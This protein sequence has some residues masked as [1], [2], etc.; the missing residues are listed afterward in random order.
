MK[1]HGLP[2][3]R[4]SNHSPIRRPNC[5]NFLPFH[6]TSLSRGII[7][8]LKRTPIQV[9]LKNRT[10][11]VSSSISAPQSPRF[12]LHPRSL[13]SFVP[14]HGNSCNP[15]S[16]PFFRPLLLFCL[17]P[18]FYFLP[19]WSSLMHFAGPREFVSPA[20]VIDLPLDRAIEPF[21]AYE[22]RVCSNNE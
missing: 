5:E 8:A 2:A 18:N 20:A 4:S 7:P 16:A 12:L 6:V 21:D 17:E 15:P 1:P 10:L 9:M 22:L 14:V 19:H 11:F 13:V 3:F